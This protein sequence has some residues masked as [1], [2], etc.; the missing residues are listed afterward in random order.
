MPTIAVVP[1]RK[2]SKRVPYKNRRIVN[3]QPLL[4]YTIKSARES[5]NIDE[6]ILTTDDEVLIE[7][8]KEMGISIYERPSNLADDYANSFD[9]MKHVAECWETKHKT[10]LENLVMLQITTPLREKGLIDKCLEILKKDTNATSLLTVCRIK[11]FLGSIKNN[12]W[13][14]DNPANPPARSQ[15]YESKFYPSGSLYVFRYQ[16]SLKKGT[17]WGNYIIPVEESCEKWVNIDDEKDFEKLENILTKYKREYK[18]LIKN[19]KI[20]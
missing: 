20:S 3:N 16:N 13:I 12:Y 14:S 8:G 15:E 6:I 11:K 5:L 10:N 17:G 9:V 19:E 18:H 4:S 2:N 1:A 7:Q